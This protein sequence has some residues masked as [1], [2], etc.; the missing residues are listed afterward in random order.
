MILY[1]C[2]IMDKIIWWH[3]NL[4]LRLEDRKQDF[5]GVIIIFSRRGK[6]DDLQREQGHIPTSI[7]PNLVNACAL[8]SCVEIL[9][10]KNKHQSRKP[11]HKRKEN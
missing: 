4:K 11:S 8:V 6:Y 3:L 1:Y 9:E 2:P 7:T 5:L 10:D